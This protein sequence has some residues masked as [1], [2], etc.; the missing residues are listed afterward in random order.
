[1]KKEYSTRIIYAIHMVICVLGMIHYMWLPKN[2]FIELSMWAY[3]SLIYIATF[4]LATAVAGITELLLNVRIKPMKYRVSTVASGLL[5]LAVLVMFIIQ[6]AND[7]ALID[8]T[9]WLFVF[10][11]IGTVLIVCCL[12]LSLV[13]RR[14]RDR[15]EYK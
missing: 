15:K 13:L 4:P 10:M 9:S 5:G 1:M 14:K 7:T 3:G 8:F 6:R 11:W 2:G 12:V